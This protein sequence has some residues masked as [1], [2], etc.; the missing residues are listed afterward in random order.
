MHFTTLS[1]AN[2]ISEL[3]KY[4]VALTL[5]HQHLFQLEEEVR[6]AVLGN[7]G[8][9]ISFRLGPEDARIVGR[10]LEPVFTPI[11]LMNLPNHDILL[12]LMID[13]T[14]SQPFSATTL[15]PNGINVL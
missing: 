3:R 12:K 13:G 10:E 8:T 4:G 14:P 2:M 5:A 15:H 7:V 1:V 6:H 11:D 9:T